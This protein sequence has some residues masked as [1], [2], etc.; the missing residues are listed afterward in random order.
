MI[1]QTFCDHCESWLH[2]R[3]VDHCV[4]CAQSLCT[5][6]ASLTNHRTVHE[7]PAAWE[8]DARPQGWDYLRCKDTPYSINDE[9]A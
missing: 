9:G 4:D 6:C 1:V 2:P 7:G 8:R 3:E 5:I